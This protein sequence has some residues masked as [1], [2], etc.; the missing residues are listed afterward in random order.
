MAGRQSQAPRVA[1]RFTARRSAPALTPA[2]AAALQTSP[3]SAEPAAPPER[4]GL[5][6]HTASHRHLHP[7]RSMS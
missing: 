7:A 6:A 2:N 3:I 1:L 4:P 5:G